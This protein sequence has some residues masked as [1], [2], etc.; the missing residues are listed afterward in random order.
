MVK[1]GGIVHTV[2]MIPGKDQDVLRRVRKKMAQTLSYR[3]GSALVPVGAL[4]SLL[5]RQNSNEPLREEAESVGLVNVSVQ[6]F[7]IVLC[8]DEDSVDSRIDAIA[9]RNINESILAPDWDGR[10]RPY[11]R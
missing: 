10:F 5:G 7:R 8:Q 4:R 6:R 2:E 11:E 3:I 9:D 1:Q